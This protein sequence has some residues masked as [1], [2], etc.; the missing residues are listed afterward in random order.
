MNY[1]HG[2][3]KTKTYIVWHSMKARCYDSNNKHYKDYGGR[4]ITYQDNWEDFR[5]FFND[6]GE[7]PKGFSLERKD[8]NGNYTKE[9]CCYIPM[10]E[11]AYNRRDTIRF[12]FNG[13]L[14][15]LRKICKQLGLPYA[16]VYARLFKLGWSFEESIR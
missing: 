4:G 12:T 15:P 6:L 13:E 3:S 10:S 14:Q 7:C 8:V 9:N 11:Q 2:M 1:S 16:R 5:N